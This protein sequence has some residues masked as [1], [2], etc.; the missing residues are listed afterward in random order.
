MSSAA[1]AEPGG[2]RVRMTRLERITGSPGVCACSGRRMAGAMA[3]GGRNG[4]CSFGNRPG[5]WG[6]FEETPWSLPDQ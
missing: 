5:A 4:E 6:G 3:V 1:G 2:G